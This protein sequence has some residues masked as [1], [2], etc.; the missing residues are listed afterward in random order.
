MTVRELLEIAEI[1]NKHKLI[2]QYSADT[3]KSFSTWFREDL[4]LFIETI[5]MS[6]GPIET[7]FRILPNTNDVAKVGHIDFSKLYFN[8]LEAAAI[9]INKLEVR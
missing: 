9:A 8:N 7:K 2:E 1:K 6:K 4:M 5:V 3:G